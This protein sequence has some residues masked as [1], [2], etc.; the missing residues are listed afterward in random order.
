LEEEE[1]GGSVGEEEESW[2][3]LDEGEE[4]GAGE[5]VADLSPWLV[6]AVSEGGAFSSSPWGLGCCGGGVARASASVFCGLFSL[7]VDSVIRRTM[8]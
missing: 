7:A 3:G 6:G 8:S 1:E 4:E 5:E 2:T